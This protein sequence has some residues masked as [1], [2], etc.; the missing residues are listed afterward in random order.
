MRYRSTPGQ[1][2]PVGS[3]VTAMSDL[4]RGAYTGQFAFVYEP[5]NNPALFDQEVFLASHE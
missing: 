3:H 2:E 1:K 5:E 4:N